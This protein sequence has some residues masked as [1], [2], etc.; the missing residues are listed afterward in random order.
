KF[1]HIRQPYLTI[2]TVCEIDIPLVT[3]RIVGVQH[4][5][6]RSIGA[7]A[8][9]QLEH[10]AVPKFLE[11]FSAIRLDPSIRSSEGVSAVLR[12]TFPSAGERIE[13]MLAVAI[14]ARGWRSSFC[15]F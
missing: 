2:L 15:D 1:A 7:G 8:L 9:G 10:G 5:T 12:M 6:D 13:V 4:Q 3:Q 11:N 14:D